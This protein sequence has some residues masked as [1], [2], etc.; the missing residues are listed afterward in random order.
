MRR[1]LLAAL[2]CL[3]AACGGRS[4]PDAIV[5]GARWT[6]AQRDLE[7]NGWS[8]TVARPESLVL[9]A[10]ARGAAYRY[11]HADGTTVDIVT[12]RQGEVER[13]DRIFDLGGREQSSLPLRPVQPPR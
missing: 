9:R 12:E 11:R 6:V 7:S 10:G 3:L 1:P 5:H 4:E 13:V 2:A 8:P